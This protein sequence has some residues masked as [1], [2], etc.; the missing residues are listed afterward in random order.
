MSIYNSELYLGGNGV[1]THIIRDSLIKSL[2]LPEDPNT[3]S[4]LIWEFIFLSALH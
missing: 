3:M 1:S 2:N 4:R